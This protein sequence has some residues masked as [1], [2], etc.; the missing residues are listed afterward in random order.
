M[1]AFFLHVILIHCKLVE[2]ERVQFCVI[3]DIYLYANSDARTACTCFLDAYLYNKDK[4]FVQFETDT[5][6]V[7]IEPIV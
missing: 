7:M 6:R 2:S 4:P 5:D 1:K 3:T